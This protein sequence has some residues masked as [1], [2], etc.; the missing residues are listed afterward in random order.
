MIG[1]GLFRRINTTLGS[2]LLNN[3][4]PSIGLQ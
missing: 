2:F 4:T 3:E 1:Y